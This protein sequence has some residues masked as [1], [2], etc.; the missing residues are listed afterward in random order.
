MMHQLITDTEFFTVVCLSSDIYDA[1]AKPG[2]GSWSN[3]RFVDLGD[4]VLVFDAMST[5]KT[6]RKLREVATKLIGKPIKNLMN[7]HYHCDH[8]W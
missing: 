6:A 7:S 2:T 3:A 4:E 1:L 8:T 5:P